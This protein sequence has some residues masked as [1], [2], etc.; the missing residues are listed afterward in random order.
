MA[1]G[2]AG[3]EFRAYCRVLLGW[4]VRTGGA[5]SQKGGEVW[6]GVPD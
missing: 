1:E 5:C 2:R 3:P 4:D 6:G